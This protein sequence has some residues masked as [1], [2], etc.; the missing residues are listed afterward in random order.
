ML[1]KKAPIGEA[2]LPQIGPLGDWVDKFVSRAGSTGL[3]VGA[4]IGEIVLGVRLILGQ[5][6]TVLGGTREEK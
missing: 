3:V 6:P 4:A 2:L 5:Q 1:L